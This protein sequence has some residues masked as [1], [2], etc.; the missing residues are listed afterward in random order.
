MAIRVVFMCLL[1]GMLGWGQTA[2]GQDGPVLKQRPEPVAGVYQ[3]DMGTRFLLSMINSVS[4]KDALPGDRLYLQTAFPI[5]VS[6][7]IVVP[8]G[9]WVT[10][11]ITDVKKP[12]RVKGRGEL[13]VRFDSLT[14]PNGVTKEFR[15]DLG[16]LDSQLGETLKR[17][18]S[19]VESPGNK[20]GDSDTVLGTTVAGGVIGA[21]IGAA[22][23]HAAG[24]SVIGIGAG[25]AAGLIQVLA[26]RGPDATLT[27]G[28]TVEMVLDRP[29]VFSNAD[30]DLSHAPAPASLSQGAAPAAEKKNG[31][32][33]RKPF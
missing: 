22:A 15:S 20:K 30:L 31:I 25:A 5:L 7:H 8:Q 9:S 28:S 6:G 13:R 18:H 33:P 26:T 23:G 14:L 17:E 32:N 19:G 27:K 21:G 11:T 16:S 29:L 10:G 4:T 2:P 1:G 12:G 3:V 24:G